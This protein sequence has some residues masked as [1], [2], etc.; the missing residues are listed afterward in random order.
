FKIK[1]YFSSFYLFQVKFQREVKSEREDA[2]SPLPWERVPPDKLY[3]LQNLVLIIF[4]FSGWLLLW[5]I[6]HNL[7][8][9]F[10]QPPRLQVAVIN[11]KP[12]PLV[13]FAPLP[14]LLCGL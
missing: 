5:E 3:L 4:T 13:K 12:L 6:G 8:L 11:T 9:S 10:L 2:P 1:D 7:L 14:K